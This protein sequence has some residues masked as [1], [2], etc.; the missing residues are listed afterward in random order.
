MVALIHVNTIVGISRKMYAE[1]AN[2]QKPCNHF[3]ARVL[4]GWGI[5]N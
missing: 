1:M 3:A 5:F 4:Q 2:T